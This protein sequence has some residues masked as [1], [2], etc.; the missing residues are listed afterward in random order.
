MTLQLW[1]DV[2]AFVALAVNLGLV[3]FNFRLFM[4]RLRLEMLLR[5]I[6]LMAFVNRHAPIWVPWCDVYGMMM[7][8]DVEPMP[9][10]RP[11]D[12]WGR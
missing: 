2:T 10:R 8:I 11:R 3:V 9:R 5:Q 1:M 6:V 7:R 4:R 12:N